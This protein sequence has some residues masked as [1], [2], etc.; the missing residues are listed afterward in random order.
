MHRGARRAPIFK[1]D[2]HCTL[3]LDCIGDAVQRSGLEVHAYALM[4]NHF[5]LLVRSP[6]ATLSRGM[7]YLLSTY[8]QRVNIARGWDGPLFRGRFKSQLVTRD[9]YLRH[10][11][12]YI[13]LN[14]VRAHLVARPEDE[15]WTSFRAHLG[16]EG[17]MPWLHDGAVR[18]WFGG[19]D[20]LATWVHAV[21]IGR[22]PAPDVMNR[23]TGLF[24]DEPASASPTG[25]VAGFAAPPK[26][27]PRPDVG[28]L[29]R[30]LCHVTGVS[31]VQ[32]KLARRGR[33]ANRARRFAALTL[34]NEVGLSQQEVAELLATTVKAVAGIVFRAA[35]L[36]SDPSFALWR[37]RWADA[38]DSV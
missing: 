10:L 33:S 37:E 30:R 24:G 8:V 34:V 11:M 32:L 7:K 28:A 3:F 36:G 25:D 21:Q 15:C 23:E 17:R 18:E 13:H 38:T 16:L 12:A 14:P 20:A 27:T 5:H 35:Q 6:R 26:V 19:A 4:P 22:E 29:V 9:D 2:D 1:R 31:E